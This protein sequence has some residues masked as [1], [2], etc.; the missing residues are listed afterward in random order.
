M[1]LSLTDRP[2]VCCPIQPRIVGTTTHRC[3]A[4][5][6]IS[7]NCILTEIEALLDTHH[8]DICCPIQPRIVATTTYSCAAGK[9]ISSNCVLTEIEALL[10]HLFGLVHN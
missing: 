3:T 2:G 6:G 4:E 9:G 1:L 8:P 7:S 10:A 5:K